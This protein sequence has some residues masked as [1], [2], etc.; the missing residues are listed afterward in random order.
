MRARILSLQCE[1]NPLF[2]HYTNI[3]VEMKTLTFKMCGLVL[4]NAAQSQSNCF[5]VSHMETI[6]VSGKTGEVGQRGLS[7]DIS[8]L[9]RMM[10]DGTFVKSPPTKKKSKKETTPSFTDFLFDVTF[11]IKSPCVLP[12]WSSGLFEGYIVEVVRCFEAAKFK[13]E[14]HVVWKKSLESLNSLVRSNQL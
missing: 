7:V 12:R 1:S 10:P 3:T 4:S 11:L 6:I 13:R 8:S 14:T 2:Q 9:V 5:D